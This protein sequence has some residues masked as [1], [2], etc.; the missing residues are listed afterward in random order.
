MLNLFMIALGLS[1]DA[2]AVSMS[3]GMCVNKI[4]D[5]RGFFSAAFGWSLM[6]GLFQGLMPLVGYFL[7]KAFAGLISSVD[8]WVA[9]VLLVIIGGKMAWEAISSRGEAEFCS[10]KP[11]S[12]KMILTQAIATSID[13]LAVGVSFA[14]LDINI[15][16]AAS[17]I[18]VVTLV[19]SVIG[20][21]IGRGFGSLLKTKAEI[22]GGVVLILIGVKILLEHTVLA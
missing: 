17:F 7:G 21:Y 1:M 2:S 19:C 20:S 14:L 18:A 10:V 11:L 4:D 3:N 22:F 15:V 13:A 9:F 12:F 8:H 16:A 6:F 5:K